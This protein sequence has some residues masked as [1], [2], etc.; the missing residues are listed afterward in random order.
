MKQ[1]WND[2][3]IKERLIEGIKNHWYHIDTTL[4][5]EEPRWQHDWKDINKYRDYDPFI[6]TAVYFIDQAQQCL[7]ITDD[8]LNE[9]L[10]EK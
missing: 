5:D 3:E 10:K 8:E 6:T 7:D 2:K 4:T 1:R 9:L